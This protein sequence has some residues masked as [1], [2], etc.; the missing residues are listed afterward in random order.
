VS[1]KLFTVFKYSVLFAILAMLAVFPWVLVYL[2]S[3]LPPDL[4][5]TGTALSSTRTA[6]AVQPTTDIL[7]GTAT[8]AGGAPTGTI[9]PSATPTNNPTSTP[10]ATATL[11][12]PP[13]NTPTHTASPTPVVL[14]IASETIFAYTCPG[15]DNRLGFIEA[16][17]TFTIIG[18]D[19]SV[20]DGETV[21]WLL[22]TDQ[23]DSPQL[24]IKASEFATISVPD[25][26]EFL[27]RAACRR[28]E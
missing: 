14:G 5:L 11:T 13:T 27:P 28:V 16:E 12:P 25:Y 23:A 9:L 10:T 22:I 8:S 1:G 24:W 2:S 15:V 17:E 6:R 7:A 21:T 19:E 3:P 4:V 26:K 20:V 18:W